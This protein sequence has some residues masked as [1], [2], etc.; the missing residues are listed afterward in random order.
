MWLPNTARY[1]RFLMGAAVLLSLLA[2]ERTRPRTIEQIFAAAKAGRPSDSPATKATAVASAEAVAPAEAAAPDAPPEKTGLPMQEVTDHTGPDSL[3][4]WRLTTAEWDS[5]NAD[6]DKRK[7][8]YST[9]HFGRFCLLEGTGKPRLFYQVAAHDSTWAE[10]DLALLDVEITWDMESRGIELDTVNLDGR[11][12]AELVLR[13]RPAAYGSGGG[14]VWDHVSVIDVSSSP[15]LVFR[16][17][18][19]VEEEAF[20]GYATMHGIKMEPGEEFTGCKRSFKV[21]GRELVLGPVRTIGNTKVGDCDLTQL[22]AG[23]Y[24]YQHGKLLRVSQ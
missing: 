5:L 6:W 21:R 17:L 10:I 13:F 20:A 12:A 22:S 11:G 1:G 15:M 2:C 23:R 9:T 16:A 4:S 14:R 19:A 18:L 3:A 7:D 8:R 24:R